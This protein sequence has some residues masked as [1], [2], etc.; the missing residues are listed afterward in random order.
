MSSS[1][2]SGLI[3]PIHDKCTGVA[4]IELCYRISPAFTQQ[5]VRDSTW[6]MRKMAIYLYSSTLDFSIMSRWRAGR[7]ASHS[8]PS[9]SGYGRE[10]RIEKKFFRFLL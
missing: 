6:H 8:P 4:K 9:G 10:A 5:V 7:K 3:F 2:R 1:E